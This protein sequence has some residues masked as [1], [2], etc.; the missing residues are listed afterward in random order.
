[1][2]TLY[3]N[4][5]CM[6]SLFDMPLEPNNCLREAVAPIFKS[7]RCFEDM[8]K[9]I[10]DYYRINENIFL[11]HKKDYEK[12]KH[13]WISDSDIAPC[14]VTK[15]PFILDLGQICFNTRS[16]YDLDYAYERQWFAFSISNSSAYWRNEKKNYKDFCNI[17]DSK[18]FGY[19]PKL[20]DQRMNFIYFE[21]NPPLRFRIYNIINQPV[22][23]GKL[24]IHIYPTGH[25]S[26]NIAVSYIRCDEITT[27]YHLDSVIR[28]LKPWKKNSE[29]IIYSK[30]GTTSLNELV[31][32]V[33][34]RISHSFF[35]IEKTIT[36]KLNWNCSALIISDNINKELRNIVDYVD[37]ENKF[38]R[39]VYLRDMF[40]FD[41]KYVNEYI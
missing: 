25:I 8:R 23:V 20:E 37:C 40:S 11:K 32:I 2:K 24:F 35:S 7:K 39:K 21:L 27:K 34:N 5:S 10:Y 31:K 4:Q 6:F 1:M 19:M 3:I 14:P 36:H 16:V 18:I 9:S 41:A 28:K 38:K 33:L 15:A 30:L 13:K 17:H 26:L 12:N 29:L 22:G